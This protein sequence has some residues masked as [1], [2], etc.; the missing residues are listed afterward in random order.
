MVWPGAPLAYVLAIS[1]PVR[2]RAPS[3]TQAVHWA[4]FM[5]TTVTYLSEVTV[6][7]HVFIRPD[8]PGRVQSVQIVDQTPLAA[9]HDQRRWPVVRDIPGLE[10]G[11]CQ[12]SST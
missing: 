1:K 3:A 11:R 8:D 2:S 9:G 5:A 12:I 6:P 7:S 4:W 10:R